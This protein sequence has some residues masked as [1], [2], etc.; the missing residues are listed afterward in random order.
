M[1][2]NLKIKLRIVPRVIQ[3]KIII[4]IIENLPLKTRIKIMF[5]NFFCV[6][7]PSCIIMI[8]LVMVIFGFV[9][10]LMW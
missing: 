5:L 2:T 6:I 4:I 8:S 3:Y 1:Y 10:M 9:G 7:G